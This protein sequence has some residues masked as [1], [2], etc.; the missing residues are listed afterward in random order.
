[1]TGGPVMRP[2]PS[3][4][5]D[6]GSLSPRRPRPPGRR[7]RPPGHSFPP[8]TTPQRITHHV[9]GASLGVTVDLPDGHLRRP[10]RRP[11]VLAAAEGGRLAGDGPGVRTAGEGA[12]P[13]EPDR[14][15]VR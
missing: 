12:Y 10:H 2:A 15:E 8:A 7:P 4:P 5:G 6:S 14:G 9:R 13:P 3:R 11:A 1:M